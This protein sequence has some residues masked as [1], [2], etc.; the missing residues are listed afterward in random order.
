MNSYQEYKLKPLSLLIFFIF[1]FTL[2]CKSSTDSVDAGTEIT[3]TPITDIKSYVFGHSLIV[4][5]YTSSPTEEKKV[6]H[7]INKLAQEANFNYTAD[8]QYGFLRQHAD[9]STINP[10]WGFDEVSSTWTN[11][12]TPFANVDFN[13]IMMT[14]ANFIQYQGPDEPYYDDPNVTPL[15][16]TLEIFDQARAAHPDIPFYIYE[17]WP[18]MSGYGTFPN[19]I[20]FAQYNNDTI[21]GNFHNWFIEYHDSLLSARPGS[22]IKMIPVGPILSKLFRDTNLSGLSITD[23]YEDDSPHG[24]PTLYFLASL[25]TYM[26]TFKT[27][28]PL[29]YIAPNT[30]HE[31]VRNN[32]TS[33]V[34][35][36][37]N[38][39][40]NFNHENGDSRVF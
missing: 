12:S 34:N 39:L 30:V 20:D 37:W 14:P 21:G 31:L 26:A 28:A 23:L 25:V 6:P 29:T 7:W 8:G 33:T 11:S 24:Q 27:Q 10:Q 3:Q 40:Q 1:L 17:N 13:N 5:E 2:S 35:F 32:Y 36:I 22:Q 9:F 15:S 18:D 38:E 4:H 16:A 19:S